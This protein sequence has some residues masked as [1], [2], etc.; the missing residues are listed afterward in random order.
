MS[1]NRLF[2]VPDAL[3]KAAW[4]DEDG[5]N[6]EYERSINDPDGFW[7]EHGKR[8][9]WITPFT[10]VKN[11]SLEGDVT[12]KW[13]EDGT[14]NA[15]AN[16]LDRHL[17]TRGDQTAIIWEGDD[18]GVSEHITYRDL[19]ERVCRLAGALKAQGAKKGDRIT[20]Y[21]PMIPEATIAMLAC[22]R[23]GAVHSVVF[24][25]FSPD[26][27][28]GRIQDCDS[29]ILITADEGLRGGRKVPL[30]SN[31]DAALQSCPSIKTVVVVK[32]TGGDITMTEGRDVWYHDICAA[33]PKDCPAEE[34]NAEDSLFILYTSGRQ[35]SRK[36]F[37][38]P[39]AAIWFMR[40]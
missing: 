9:D 40:R 36:G 39:P 8:L 30:K 11:T 5:Y 16:C 32:R 1:D 19:H 7:G 28:A 34:M 33:A 2:P 37:C 4:L 10:K 15:S 3:K 14:L 22:A 17:A 23:I 38:T 24:G 31:A 6:K 12:I 26:A 35:E 20:L 29:N 18:P 27:L 13:F 25:G 21:M